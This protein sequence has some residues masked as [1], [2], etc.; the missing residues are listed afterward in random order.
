MCIRD[1]SRSSHTQFLTAHTDLFAPRS[2]WQIDV[3]QPNVSATSHMPAGIK[4]RRSALLPIALAT[5]ALVPP[6]VPARIES[7]SPRREVSD[8]GVI[9]TDQRVTPAGVQSVF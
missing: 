7:Q 1:R 2:G 6:L 3:A 4:A 5:T 9:A 8:P